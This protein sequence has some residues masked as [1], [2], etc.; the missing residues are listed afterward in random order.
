MS[1]TQQRT[2]NVTMQ[3]DQFSSTKINNDA[4]MKENM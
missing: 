1:N 3:L 4:K 2:G